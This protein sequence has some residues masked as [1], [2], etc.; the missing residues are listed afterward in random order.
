[1]P[2]RLKA[3]LLDGLVRKQNGCRHFFQHEPCG[4]A[5]HQFAETGVPVPSHD[6]QRCAEGLNLAKN[7]FRNVLVASLGKVNLEIVAT[8]MLHESAFAKFCPLGSLLHGQY[9]DACVPDQQR[10]CSG[11]SPRGVNTGIPSNQDTLDREVGFIAARHDQNR[12][13]GMEKSGFEKDIAEPLGVTALVLRHDR[14]VGRAKPDH[15]I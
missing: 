12:F 5:E 3:S 1:M 10:N 4:A 8:E 9:S 13:A 2:N 14:N 11:D 6:Q 7:G 15:E